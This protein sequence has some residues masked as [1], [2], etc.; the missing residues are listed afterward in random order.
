MD[1]ESYETFVNA[2]LKP[3]LFKNLTGTGLQEEFSKSIRIRIFENSITPTKIWLFEN[4]YPFQTVSDLC[5]RIYIKSG[6][7]DEY[8][9]QNQCLLIQTNNK[10][11]HFQ[12]TFKDLSSE[13]SLLDSPFEVLSKN[14]PNLMFVDNAGNSKFVEAESRLNLLLESV[15]PKAESEEHVLD[16]YLYRNLYER[17]IGVKPVDRFHW[18][19]IFRVYFPEKEKNYED[20]SLP[21]AIEGYKETLVKRLECRE[22]MIE[23]LDKELR[24]P[25]SSPPGINPTLSNIRNL[26]FR[27]NTIIDKRITSYYNP[28]DIEAMFYDTPVS[29]IVPYIRFYPKTSDPISKV[30]VEGGPLNIPS[31]KNPELIKQWALE[32]KSPT[33]EESVIMLKILVREGG[34]S[35]NPIYA[36][37]YC[38]EDGTAK[39]IV[40]P[41]DKTRA[42]SPFIDLDQLWRR[43]DEVCKIFPKIQPTLNHG[44]KPALTMFTPKNISLDDAYVILT[45][46]LELEEGKII[47]NKELKEKINKRLPYYSAFFQPTTSPIQFQHPIQSLRFKCMD[48][49][50]TPARDFQYLH[51]IIDLYKLQGRADIRALVPYYMDEFEVPRV[52]AETRVASFLQ[53]ISKY[54][55]VNDEVMDYTL[56]KNPG[57]DIAVFGRYPSYTIHIYRVNSLTNLRRIK[58]LF[59]L[60][61]RLE[62]EFFEDVRYCIEPVV[63][64]DKEEEETVEKEA[65]EEREEAEAEAEAEAEEE[66]PLMAGMTS[67]VAQESSYPDASVSIDFDFAEFGQEEEDAVPELPLETLVAEADLEVKAEEEAEAE[68][69]AEKA[70]VTLSE[71]E[72]EITDANELKKTKGKTY[73][74]KRLNFYDKRLF[75]YTKSHPSLKKYSSMCAANAY[76]QPTVMSID[77]FE[78]MK[79][80]YQIG[81]NYNKTYPIWKEYPIPSI[82]AKIT[83]PKQNPIPDGPPGPKAPPV[84]V[85]TVLKYGSSGRKEQD[86]VY[87]C[88]AYWCRQDD[89]VVLTAD[90]LSAF[91]R[92]GNSK[93]PKSCPICRKGPVV[94]RLTVEKNEAVIDRSG[95]TKATET[96]RHLYIN[97]LKKM[98]HPEGLYLPCCFLKDKEIFEEKH[99][100]YK[101]RKA[102]AQEAASGIPVSESIER[103]VREKIIKDERVRIRTSYAEKLDENK[104]KTWYILGS[105]KLPLEILKDGP[106]IGIVHPAV[107]KFFLQD[108]LTDLVKHDRTLWSLIR[109]GVAPDDEV[110]SSGFL[111]IAVENRNRFLGESFLSAIA[112]F[113]N[114]NSATEMIEYMRPYLLVNPTVFLSL[115]YGNLLFDFYNP[116]MAVVGDE[117]EEMNETD[118]FINALN[119]FVSKS[120]VNGVGTGI[121]KE[122]LIRWYKAFTAFEAFMNDTSQ[123]KEFRHFAKFLA[124]PDMLEWNDKGE[125]RKNGIMFIVLEVSLKEKT[126][127]V[128]CPPYGISPRNSHF[129]DGCDVAF[130]IYYKGT[131]IWEPVVYTN[132]II[133]E[134]GNSNV[135]ENIMVFRRDKKPD[136]PD[137]VKKRVEE[138]EDMCYRSGLGIYTDSLRISPSTLLPLSAAADFQRKN[139]P[140]TFHSIVRDAYNHVSFVI[141]KIDETPENLVL[142]PVIDDGSY[143]SKPV[144]LSSQYFMQHLA[145]YAKAVDFYKKKLQPYLRNFTEAIQNSYKF[146]MVPKKEVQIEKSANDTIPEVRAIRLS[147]G[148]LVPVNEKSNLEDPDESI[149]EIFPW[150]IDIKLAFGKYFSKKNTTMEIT[151]EELEEVYQH[152]RLTFAN[153]VAESQYLAKRFKAILYKNGKANLEISLNEKRKRLLIMFGYTVYS[154]LDSAIPHPKSKPSLKRVDCRL[155]STEGQCNN[156][157]VWKQ[158]EN[159]CLLHV[160]EKKDPENKEESVD[161]KTLMI[162]RIIDE[163]IRF[164]VKREELLRKKVNTY[165]KLT[166]GFRTGKDEKKDQYIVPENSADWFELLRMDWL[167]D[168]KEQPRHTEEFWKIPNTPWKDNESLWKVGPIPKIIYKYYEKVEP[169]FFLTP[170]SNSIFPI[171]ESEF[172]IT[173]NMLE[174][175]GQKPGDTVLSSQ[176]V[177]EFVSKTLGLSIIQIVYEDN[178]S[179]PKIFVNKIILDNLRPAPYLCIVK[180]GKLLGSNYKEGVIGIISSSPKKVEP[181]PSTGIFNKTIQQKIQEIIAIQKK[182]TTAPVPEP[183][184]EP[185][186][187]SEPTS[188][189]KKILLKKGTKPE[190]VPEPVSAPEPAPEPTSIAKK[191]LL[192]KGTKPAPVSNQ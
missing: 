143:H 106:Q 166:Q 68:A 62:Y 80:M 33:P 53:N 169:L 118:T 170:S 77:E 3:E 130:L 50:R 183:E 146:S 12:Y 137:V 99:P 58:T 42:L 188:I 63:R 19:G 140:I 83:I 111:R 28:F 30:H 94:N 132:N 113:Y 16:L 114:K 18:E 131:G 135:H 162:K 120:L 156:R 116:D 57:I 139:P 9:P 10:Y 87:I 153:W 59:T 133:M 81:K 154:W 149:K 15:F 32:L 5:T 52:V 6:K 40:Q 79:K 2:V 101:S 124:L 61:M 177:C 13:E 7:R 105:E 91:D 29:E 84:E 56:E 48:N 34:G 115:N 31:M 185:V 178:E 4:L 171:L 102:L 21:V 148:M 109:E 165:T 74:L 25:T 145:F 85:I 122:A 47:T 54:V 36:T 37:M 43:L 174:E 22:K 82:K 49:F 182:R 119:R 17:Y 168:T 110:S 184:P 27:W 163:L 160:P 189:A 180:T 8:H 126:M 179:S 39:F 136:W 26:K 55:I 89:I 64:Q 134:N 144:E 78:R 158:E 181:V 167:K 159:R 65:E 186:P 123:T 93:P 172:Q 129:R 23:K 147:N 192:K 95:T 141:F 96:K 66:G 161:V 100:A 127:E 71:D 173:S 151:A 176:E 75:Q 128:R 150:M 142:V 190:P 41:D 51:R 60:L 76:K 90:Y 44:R 164:P 107:D 69:E 20:G 191:I 46:N 14:E 97:F 24:N 45:L 86:N 98:V 73:F 155:V 175:K 92:N 70:S 11:R 125:I 112:P 38:F 35:V 187:V 152:L 108:S 157:C 1:P 138:Y 103:T 121:H 104:T 88:S 67:R 117:R 72:N